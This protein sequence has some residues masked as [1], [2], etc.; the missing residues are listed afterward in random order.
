MRSPFEYSRGFINDTLLSHNNSQWNVTTSQPQDL[1]R[2]A[3]LLLVNGGGPMISNIEI[4]LIWY[5]GSVPYQSDLTAMNT[6]LVQS[7]FMNNFIEYATP[8]QI[9][10]KG[11][12]VGSYTETNIRTSLT[13]NDVK[14]YIRSLVQTGKITPN[15]NSYYSIYMKDGVT[16]TDNT[17]AVSCQGFGAYHNAVYIGDIY[18]IELTYFAVLPMC[19]GTLSWLGVA[20]AHELAEAVT[21]SWNGWR[22]ADVQG[23]A[24]SGE[25]IADI[26]EPQ[27]GSCVLTTAYQTQTQPTVPT[28]ATTTLV[29]SVTTVPK[30]I[31]ITPIFLGASASFQTELAAFYNVLVTSSIFDVLSEYGVSQGTTKASY[32]EANT[33]SSLDIESTLKTYLRNL[34]KSGTLQPN[35]N[36]FYPIHL[37]PNSGV[38]AQG[39]AMD[40]CNYYCNYRSS[41]YV[42]D[43]SQAQYIYFEV[44][45]DYTS[46]NCVS[47]CGYSVETLRNIEAAASGAVVSQLTSTWRTSNG[48][49]ANTLCSWKMAPLNGATY[50]VQK[51][52]SNKY[53]MCL[54]ALPSGQSPTQLPSNPTQ[55]PYTLVKN[56]NGAGY[57]NLANFYSAIVS[58]GYFD[59]LSQY[60]I[61]RGT[62]KP[63]YVEATAPS[64]DQSSSFPTYMKNLVRNG[65]IT[66]NSNSFY[67]VHLPPNTDFK[68]QGQ[69][70]CQSSCSLSGSVYIG[71]VSS[72]TYLYYGI[73]PDYSSTSGSCSTGC[74]SSPEPLRNIEAYSSNTILA[75][76][77]GNWKT[78]N[79]ITSNTICSG[80][81]GPLKIG[82]NVW[83]VRKVW[84][85]Q[86]QACLVVP[87]V[88]LINN[89]QACQ[90]T[91]VCASNGWVCCVAP[92]EI[93][94]GRPTCRPPN[95]CAGASSTLQWLPIPFTFYQGGDISQNTMSV[96]SCTGWCASVSNCVGAVYTKS[97][98]LCA[99]KSIL[100]INQVSLNND[101]VTYIPSGGWAP[102]FDFWDNVISTLSASG[103]D[104]CRGKCSRTVGCVAGVYGPGVCR[105]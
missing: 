39:Q 57:S 62:V 80:Q 71:D 59:L 37:P 18:N 63:S 104:D 14:K 42:A 96:S 66:P 49:A 48:M 73:F 34:V 77:I 93:S 12:V 72:T 15:Q 46:G 50:S 1:H 17:G 69:S 20:T 101:G 45:P 25:E 35:I 105:L 56:G 32:V 29:N 28:P 10:G 99:L 41:V 36:S 74:G 22:V 79:G 6:F 81:V 88:P 26:C 47:Y 91:D 31:E 100:G 40:G 82:S 21:D 54:A 51:L 94:T 87:P 64:L 95:M 38:T 13:D 9:I 65:A 8:T 19:G 86:N 16:V 24:H 102:G 3:N 83:T 7:D 90:I 76:I 70:I 52:W 67:P 58:S 43:I 92:E 2:R 89:W 85:N 33:P 78:S 44:F 97:S 61:A 60:G 98:N 55:T 4:T 75:T 23:M 27:S 11:T 68:V 53:Q 30:T 5:D 103:I 84:S